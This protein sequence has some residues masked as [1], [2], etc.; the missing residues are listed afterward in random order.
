MGAVLD[1][2]GPGAGAP[3]EDAVTEA[4]VPGAAASVQPAWRSRRA[5]AVLLV[6]AVLGVA[7]DLASKT[8]AF[9]TIG[10]H[11]VV[12]DRQEVLRRTSLVGLIPP[13][14][15]RTIIPRVL[16]LS[17][18]L[19]RGAV[20]GIGAGQRWAFILFTF[21]A[22]AFAIWMF[23]WWTGPRDAGAHAA[24]AL[25]VS[26]GL[27]NLYDRLVFACVRDFIHPL[28]GVKLPFGLTW[29]GG[30]RDVWPY[31]SNLADLWLIIGIGMLMVTLFRHGR[32]QR[33]AAAR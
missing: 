25:L 18:V 8:I 33:G 4:P 20:F 13:G 2:G 1:R 12:I 23:G 10:P 15:T 24:I 32:A 7:T 22:L 3:V 27:G 17:L 29:P 9:R 31:V 11:P 26:G 28:P 5:W 6:V 19:N 14:S 21:G 16:E 30:E